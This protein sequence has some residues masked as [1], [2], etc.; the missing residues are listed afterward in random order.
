[1]KIEDLPEW[2]GTEPALLLASRKTI[3]EFS[4]MLLEEFKRFDIEPL[5]DRYLNDRHLFFVRK[6]NVGSLTCIQGDS[7]HDPAGELW[8]VVAQLNQKSGPR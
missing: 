8:S 2:L 3:D 6:K 7:V 4:P 5:A 1:M